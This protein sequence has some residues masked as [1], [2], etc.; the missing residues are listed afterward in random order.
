MRLHILAGAGSCIVCVTQHFKSC[1]DDDAIDDFCSGSAHTAGEGGSPGEGSAEFFAMCPTGVPADHC[2]PMCEAKT[3]GYLLLLNLDGED[4]KLTC[5][6]HHGLY[7]WVG[8]SADGGFI[9]TDPKA[10]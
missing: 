3:N 6:L 1:T 9:G 8:G 2:I 7:S 10:E 4:T 5:E